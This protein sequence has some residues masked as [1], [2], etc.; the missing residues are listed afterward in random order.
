MNRSQLSLH[1]LVQPRGEVQDQPREKQTGGDGTVEGVSSKEGA[2]TNTLPRGWQRLE[3]DEVARRGTGHTPNKR[4]PDYWNGGIKWVSLK[5]SGRLDAVWITETGD[6]ISDAGLKNSSAVLHP[7]GTVIVSRD[8]GVGKSGILATPM[9]V[10][11][12][13][14]TWTCGPRLNNLFLY[15]ALQSLKPEFERIARGQ[16]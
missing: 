7:A 12:H 13:F 11:Q 8:A 6:E 2:V 15:Y 1:P 9:A 16:P 4:R 10:S 3:L 5:D 14:V